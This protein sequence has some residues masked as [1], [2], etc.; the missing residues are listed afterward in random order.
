[1]CSVQSAG[2]HNVTLLNS[3]A[4]IAIMVNDPYGLVEMAH[5]LG[6][7]ADALTHPR[8]SSTHQLNRALPLLFR[9]KTAELHNE[10]FVEHRWSFIQVS[11]VVTF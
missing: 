4:S 5:P 6:H 7:S 3:G 11:V 2:E 8:V 10:I 1:M 9:N